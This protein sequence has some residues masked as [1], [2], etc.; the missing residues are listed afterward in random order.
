MWIDALD[1][2]LEGSELL[3]AARTE[4]RSVFVLPTKAGKKE[5]F[6]WE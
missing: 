1:A 3:E 4:H 5:A 6:M 2:Q